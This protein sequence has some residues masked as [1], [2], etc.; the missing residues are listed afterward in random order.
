MYIPA[1]FRVDDLS[2]LHAFMRRYSFATLVTAGDEPF[3]TRVPLLLDAASGPFGT[4][5]GHFARP[6]PHGQ[7]DHARH[8]SVAMFDGPHAYV[9]PSW[10]S[11][12]APAVPTWNYAAVHAWGNLALLAD[13]ADVAAVLERMVEVYESSSRAPWKNTLPRDTVDKLIASVVAF[14]MPIERTEGKFKLGQN[15]SA[16]DQLGAI[17]ALEASGEPESMSLAAFAR[18]HLDPATANLGR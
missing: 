10:Y 16:A 8:A 9:S 11:G 17:E 1:A 12:G 5:I 7:L 14:R 2:A 3:V 6:N 13:P 15:R 4:L 18:T